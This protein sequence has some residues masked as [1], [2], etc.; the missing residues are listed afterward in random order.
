MDEIAEDAVENSEKA[1]LVFAIVFG[2]IF[3]GL[4]VFVLLQ[5]QQKKQEDHNSPE[6]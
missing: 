5:H 6:S 3:F 2:S 4:E 1:G